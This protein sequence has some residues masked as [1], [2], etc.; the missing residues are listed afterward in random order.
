MYVLYLQAPAMDVDFSPSGDFF[1]SV[2]ADEQ[3][4]TILHHA[5]TLCIY[6]VLL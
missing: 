3:V 1:A 2:G 6:Y 5:C 4:H